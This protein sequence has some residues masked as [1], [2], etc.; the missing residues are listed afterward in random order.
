M[1]TVPPRWIEL[2]DACLS[3]SRDQKQLLASMLL[4]DLGLDDLD[5]EAILR[6]LSRRQPVES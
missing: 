5:V 1:M 6:L 2:R 3:M 4:L